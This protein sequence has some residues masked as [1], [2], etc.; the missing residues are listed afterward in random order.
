MLRAASFIS[1]T[2]A[3][4]EPEICSAMAMAPSLPEA[5]MVAFSRSSK[6]ICSPTFS[7]IRLEPS[8]M[9][10]AVSLM[11]TSSFRSSAMIKPR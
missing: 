8:G 5:T 4:S 11:V 6:R 9:M 1:P 7:P 3:A 10:V 2:K